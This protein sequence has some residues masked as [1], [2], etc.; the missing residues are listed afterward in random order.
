MDKT[1]DRLYDFVAEKIPFAIT[2]LVATSVNFGMYL[3]LVDRFLPYLPAT[4]IAYA[5]GVVLNFFMHRYFVFDLNRSASKAFG[6]TLITSGIGLTLDALIVSG[7]HRSNIYGE[8]EWLIKGTAMGILFFY[9]Y[10]S[11]KYAFEGKSSSSENG[12]HDIFTDTL[13]SGVLP[14]NLSGTKNTAT[15]KPAN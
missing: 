8:R 9:N 15:D 12:E 4:M 7:L 11:K 3:L 13:P 5:S 1:F 2:G 10:Y 14:T 6:I